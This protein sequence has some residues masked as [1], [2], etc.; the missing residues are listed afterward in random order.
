MKEKTGQL[1]VRNLDRNKVSE[2]SWKDKVRESEK[3]N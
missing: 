3:W 2:N 1:G